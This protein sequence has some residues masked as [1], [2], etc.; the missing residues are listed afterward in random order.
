MRYVPKMT[1]DNT[2]IH[3]FLNIWKVF[4]AMCLVTD[5]EFKCIIF[6]TVLP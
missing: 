4:L 5:K 3:D 2:K 6:I 1:R